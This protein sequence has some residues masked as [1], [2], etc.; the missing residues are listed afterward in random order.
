MNVAIFVG[1]ITEAPVDAI[2]T[3]T[4]PR[5]SLMMGTGGS[6]RAKGGWEILRAAEEIIEAESRRTGRR[7]LRVGAA[8]AANAGIL[9]YKTVIHCIASDPSHSSSSEVVRAC[10]VNALAVADGAACRSVAMPAFATGHA[11]FRFERS[12]RAMAEALRDAST[13]VESVVIVVLEPD[14]AESALHLLQE[15][16]PG[17]GLLR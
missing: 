4:N 5:L 16:I 1:D 6:V 7:Q 8:Y 12:V 3:S 2:C 13:S 9:P 11:H 17:A 10:V 14:R 15:V